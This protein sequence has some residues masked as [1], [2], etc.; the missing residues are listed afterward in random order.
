[1]RKNRIIGIVFG[2][3]ATLIYIRLQLIPFDYRP[4][5]ELCSLSNLLF[6]ASLIAFMYEKGR[7]AFMGG[8]NWLCLELLAAH[9]FWICY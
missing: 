2:I 7:G 4:W 1:M 9:L 5:Y 3:I 6:S 8:R